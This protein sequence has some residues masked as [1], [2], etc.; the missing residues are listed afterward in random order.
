MFEKIY[1]SVYS[2]I[3]RSVANSSRKLIYFPILHTAADMGELKASVEQRAIGQLGEERWRQSRLLIDQMWMDIE[4]VLDS[5]SLDYT[6]TRLYQD[7]LPICANE[8]AIVKDLADAG[9]RNHRLLMRLISSG[10]ILMGTESA[11]LLVQEYQLIVQSMQEIDKQCSD[12]RKAASEGLLQRRDQFIAERIN[13]TLAS[14]ETGILFLGMLHSIKGLLDGD[15]EVVSP[16]GNT[17][18]AL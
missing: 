1:P 15:I 16:L 14:G 9:S 3:M 13:K 6:K 7:G 11:E 18:S 12:S 5:F 17:Y 4:T 2:R 8:A 10:A